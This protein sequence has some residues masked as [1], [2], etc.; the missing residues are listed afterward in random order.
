MSQQVIRGLPVSPAK[1]PEAGVAQL[2]PTYGSLPVRLLP[3]LLLPLLLQLNLPRA[4]TNLYIWGCYCFF[5]QTLLLF[6]LHGAPLGLVKIDVFST[7][8]RRRAHCL[9]TNYLSSAAGCSAKIDDLPPKVANII[10]EFLQHFP[11]VLFESVRNMI[12]F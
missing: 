9:T 4:V 8:K 7:A 1:R 2:S 11:C 12:I 5:Y 10:A 3:L 6:L